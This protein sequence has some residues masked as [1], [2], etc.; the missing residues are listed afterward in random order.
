[1]SS[2]APAAP[3]LPPPGKPPSQPVLVREPVPEW[4]A[5]IQLAL[6]Q[7]RYEDARLLIDSQLK[8]RPSVPDLEAL[9][10]LRTIA[11][12]GLHDVD[13][14]RTDAAES[15]RVSGES[16]QLLTAF[17]ALGSRVDPEL[18]LSSFERLAVF[19][20]SVAR[21][22]DEDTIWRLLQLFKQ[23]HREAEYSRLV[24]VLADLSYGT[25]MPPD[26]FQKQAAA[27]LIE[28]GD[29][30]RALECA[31]KV[32]DRDGLIDIL[33][34]R[35]F[36]QLWPELER[37]SGERLE[38][39]A[40]AQLARA[41]SDF[42]AHPESLPLRLSLMRA[43]V[44]MGHLPEAE[45][46]GAEVGRTLEQMMTL[47]ESTAYVIDKDA[48]V[49]A[50]LGRR[51]E[52]DYRR[53]AL[54]ATWT[55]DRRWVINIAINRLVALFSAHHYQDILRELDRP[56]NRYQ[57]DSSPYAKQLLRVIRISSL[58]QLGRRPEALKLIPDLR[59]HD[60]DAPAATMD[61]LL[62]AGMVSE[63]EK[64]AL[65]DLKD[66]D[67]RDSIIKSLRIS[68]QAPKSDDPLAEQIRA[69]LRARPAV[70]AAFQKYARDLPENLR[71][72][73]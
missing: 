40:R 64:I 54:L 11:D 61:A 63:A 55:R 56:G 15:L 62:I 20:P 21:T 23:N 53:A 2:I 8:H 25:V 51:G 18:A 17:F 22:A 12:A 33:T 14:L 13:G 46:L 73:Y 45:K 19:N 38:V 26:E 49:L 30:K 66:A 9:R 72:T 41:Q 27:I 43:Y 71:R 5:E 24:L 3:S 70:E 35:R 29:I 7:G 58:V 67:Q 34:D 68:D 59:A 28:R 31:R 4:A 10:F 69:R 42:K 57:E 32:S 37:S 44:A 47:S 6:A 60:Q 48:D 52:A 50:M 65:A 16:V 39:P 36:E 1:M